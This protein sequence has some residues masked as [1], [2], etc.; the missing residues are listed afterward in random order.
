MRAALN[1]VECV[2]PPYSD[3][4]KERSAPRIDSASL[5]DLK[6]DYPEEWEVV[7]PK[8]V[9]CAA[10]GPRQLNRFVLEASRNA[11]PWRRRM[12]RSHS[13]PRTMKS[14][15]PHLIRERMIVL[16]VEETLRS[17]AL[18]GKPNHTVRLGLWSGFLIQRL[19]FSSGLQRKAA[20][21]TWFRRLWPLV[22]DRRLLMPLVQPRGIYCFYSQNF[23]QALTALISGRSALEVAAGDGT[24]SRLL[25]AHGASICCT[26]N[27]SWT[28]AISYPD[29]VEA[30]DATAAVTREKAAVVI[31]S[32]PPP[33][34]TFE[35]KILSASS[36]ETYVVVTTAHEF[37]A[38]NWNA[39]RA[40]TQFDMVENREWSR[41]VLPPEIDPLVLIF[42]RKK[43]R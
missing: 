31:C 43:A 28:H 3:C 16:A 20:S 27:R 21:D 1:I 17:A 5:D 9:E 26:D 18:G 36:T 11:K 4:M 35:S 23:I 10:G 41:W 40:Q 24:L 22:F 14:A 6:R 13:N 2:P 29:D 39:Y 15:L 33:N 42:Q 32:F 38:G 12:A 7:G 19:L 30:L 8:L 34:N 37:A 25:R